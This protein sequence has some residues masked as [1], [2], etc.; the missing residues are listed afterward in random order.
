MSLLRA[1]PGGSGR[2]RDDHLLPRGRLNEVGEALA[3]PVRL[4]GSVA[5]ADQRAADHLAI[6]SWPSEL[7]ARS[8]RARSPPLEVRPHRRAQVF[9]GPSSFLLLQYRDV[10]P[11]FA[12]RRDPSF[13]RY[14]FS[15]RRL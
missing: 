12:L 9:A 15:P 3:D 11:W 2:R 10:D 4:D 8:E 5:L 1:G 7:V 14:R 13:D 6:W